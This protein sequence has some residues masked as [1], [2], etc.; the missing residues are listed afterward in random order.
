M[1]IIIAVIA[2]AAA[3]A[4]LASYA[5][6]RTA[7]RVTRRKRG[8][9]HDTLE[10]EQYDV[11]KEQTRE[12]ID[13][14]LDIPFE[15]VSTVSRDGISLY[16]RYY[17]TADGAPVNIMFHGYMSVALR[18]MG[19][20]L[21]YALDCGQNVLL[22]DQRAH[23]RSGGKYLTMGVKER[24]DCLD[25]VDYAESRFGIGTKILLSGISMGAS[26][27]LMGA[28]L[29]EEGR[30]SGVVADCGYSSAGGILRKVMGDMHLPAAPIYFLMRLGAR[31]FCGFDPND[32]EV[33]RQLEGCAVPVLFIHGED[34]RFVPC[35]MGEENYRSCASDKELFTVPGAGHGLA[36]LVDRD[37][38]CAAVRSFYERTGCLNA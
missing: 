19:G 32:G 2:A 11:F 7:F 13:A 22:V 20:G 15:V 29:E 33:A 35:S 38:Y 31:L 30:I 37:G 34:D 14:A 4:L 21:A 28:C 16:G 5:V 25:W 17:H 36:F 10:G 23:G 26:T 9:V 27:V 18:D 6:C 12:L 8:G 24:Y 1:W 3:L